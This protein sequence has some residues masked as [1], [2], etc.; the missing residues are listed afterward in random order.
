[1]YDRVGC[2]L[3][4]S[5]GAHPNAFFA[6]LLVSNAV[7]THAQVAFCRWRQCSMAL[8]VGKSCS[9]SYQQSFKRD[10]N[11]VC[12]NFYVSVGPSHGLV[13]SLLV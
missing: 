8:S 3:G 1:M 4:G 9:E 7:H 10:D 11:P 6:N 12:L 5:I 13:L 2:A